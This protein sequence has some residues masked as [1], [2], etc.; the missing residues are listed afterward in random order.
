[1]SEPFRA[2]LQRDAQK[3]SEAECDGDY[4]YDDE[5]EAWVGYN[6]RDFT[7]T[8]GDFNAIKGEKREK[9]I[10]KR[11]KTMCGTDTIPSFITYGGDPRGF[12]LKINSDKLTEDEIKLCESLHF[13]R[14]WGGDYTIVKNGE[15]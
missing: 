7:H 12:V 15:I 8:T 6:R 11:I 4:Y 14:D 2:H 3:H 9:S 1:M 10:I 5:K 13:M